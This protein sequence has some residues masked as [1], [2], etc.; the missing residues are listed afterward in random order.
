[1]NC[2]VHH[3]LRNGYSKNRDVN[4]DVYDKQSP[5]TELNTKCNKNN[6]RFRTADRYPNKKSDGSFK[7]SGLNRNNIDKRNFGINSDYSQHANAGFYKPSNKIKIGDEAA[8]G[9]KVLEGIK[10]KTPVL[11]PSSTAQIAIK[12]TQAISK[13]KNNKT[14]SALISCALIFI[15]SITLLFT[16]ALPSAQYE[17]AETYTDEYYQEK[18]LAAVYGGEGDVNW[19]RF[20]EGIKINVEKVTD[21]IGIGMQNLKAF[22]T[23][24][25]FSN[26]DNNQNDIETYSD[27]GF[28][29]RVAQSEDAQKSTLQG[30]IEAV[31]KKF[32]VRIEDIQ[33]A[34]QKNKDEIAAAVDA[35]YNNGEYDDFSVTINISGSHLSQ[36]GAA[37]IMSLY[38][39]QEAGSLEE[40]RL[41]SLMKWM[42]YYDKT[43]S[44][45]LIFKVLGQKCKVKTWQGTFL[46]QYLNEQEE[47]DENQE[48]HSHK[49]IVKAN[50]ENYRTGA[51]DLMI[52]ADC[53]EMDEIQ[54]NTFVKTND[55]GE[56]VKIGK[57]VVNIDVRPRDFDEI[58][59]LTG[60]WIGDLTKRQDYMPSNLS[61]IN[62]IASGGNAG[63]I[64]GDYEWLDG[65]DLPKWV[66][67]GNLYTDNAGM[68]G[69]CTWYACDRIKQLYGIDLAQGGPMGDGGK[70]SYNARKRGYK[71]D[72]IA[73][74]GKAVCFV[75]GQTFPHPGDSWSVDTGLESAAGH[76]AIVEK[77][78]SD[79]GIWV[80]EFWGSKVDYKPHISYFTPQTAAQCDFIDFTK[81]G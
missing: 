12:A 39:I 41:S 25:G 54:V 24:I 76:I 23:F 72:H 64:S 52:V 50:Y 11:I 68:A 51:T 1:M 15:L 31:Q 3:F 8:K 63:I 7:R 27:D 30:K 44:D 28:E 57:A 6:N 74:A 59:D 36:E 26:K 13:L 62:M 71:V 38:M 46:P 75:P 78:E 77:V 17:A 55:K 79:G 65:G 34:I 20:V 29:V 45:K 19:N 81:K 40:V 9:A 22:S 37:A 5:K 66:P 80:S 61:T 48:K 4:T 18:Y 70:W 60:L 53:P 69:Q 67:Q 2:P 47:Q 10:N 21:K 33:E 49:K 35:H 56:E 58:A 43:D 73:E 32:D 16:Y 42:G 14:I